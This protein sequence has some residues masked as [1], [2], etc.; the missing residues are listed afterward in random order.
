M[1]TIS[2]CIIAKNEQEVIARC[3]ECAGKVADEIIVV[4]TG[5]TDQTHSI[6]REYTDRVFDFP[7]IDDFSAARNESFSHANMEYCLWLDADDVILEQDIVGLLRLKAALPPEVDVVMM[8]YN[9]G[10]DGQGRPNFSYY[11]ERILRNSPA[12]RWQ[13]AIHEAIAPVGNVIYSELAI[14]HRKL[15]AADPERNLRIFEGMLRRG[16]RLA[17]RERFYYARELYEH[18]RYDDAI[19]ILREVIDDGTAWLEN[20]LEACRVLANCYRA[21]GEERAALLALLH[22]LSLDAPR[23]EIC[24]DIGSW[25]LEQRQYQTAI[26]WYELAAARPRNDRSGGFVQP[27]CYGYIPYMQLCV[28]Y[29]RL[30]QWEQARRYNELA[31]QLKPEDE[32][33][34]Y[35][36]RYFQS[37][38]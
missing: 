5:S 31:G 33:Y 17:P 38:P 7:W 10:F 30:G 22:S 8:R 6:A 2:A 13:G 37:N 20:R 15:R 35:N 28:C 23:A 21:K 18:R 34:R 9:V 29:D 24:C 27:D 19:P 26:F 11:R 25:F 32:A 1:A 4:D 14:T 16:E 36:L 3:L 12:Y